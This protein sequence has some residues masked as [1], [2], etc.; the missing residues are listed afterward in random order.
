MAAVEKNGEIIPK[1]KISENTTKITNPGFKQVYRLYSKETGEAI[2]DVLTLFDEE[3]QS[4]APYELFD[5]EHTWKRKKV[6]NFVAKK[7]L[8]KIFD[9]GQCVYESP[10]V[11][12]IKAY[13]KDQI[14]KLWD[15]VKRFE[16]PHRYYVDLSPS[17]WAM[18]E[19]LLEKYSI[20]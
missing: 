7:M 14:D 8:V 15:E 1:I 9:H 4:D 6:E 13:C 20:R 5:P 10:D 17:L 12:Q 11:H 19:S 2:A 3:I 18:K 16:N